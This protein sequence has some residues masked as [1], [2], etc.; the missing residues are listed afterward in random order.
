M[1]PVQNSIQ[2]TLEV[3]T[4]NCITWNNCKIYNFEWGFIFNIYFSLNLP[5]TNK[6]W[7]KKVDKN[8]IFKYWQ[9]FFFNFLLT[10][11]YSSSWLLMT[12]KSKDYFFI[13]NFQNNFLIPKFFH[14][15]WTFISGRVH[16]CAVLNVAVLADSYHNDSAVV[17]CVIYE[18]SVILILNIS[19]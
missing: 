15:P 8:W 4:E 18:T 1:I 11:F 10:T 19:S 12:P 13:V 17:R 5:K 14:H 2:R 3:L 6:I 9:T 16:V 7:L